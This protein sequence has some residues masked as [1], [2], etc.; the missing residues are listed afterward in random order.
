MNKIFEKEPRFAENF[1]YFLCNGNIIK[2]YKSLI[3]N[4]IKNGDVILLNQNDDSD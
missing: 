2:E 4:K 1:N 3:D